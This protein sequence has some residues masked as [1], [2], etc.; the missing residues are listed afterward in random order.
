MQNLRRLL[1]PSLT[2]ALLLYAAYFLEDLLR[3]LRSGAA[4]QAHFFLR[5]AVGIGIWLAGAW[6]VNELIHVTIWNRAASSAL[7][8]RPVPQLLKH[9]VT[10]F[11]FALALTGILGFVFQK[12]VTGVWATSGVV[13]LVFGFAARSLIADL[14]CGI[15]LHLDPPFRIGDW[16]EWK[17]GN[18]EVLARVEQINWRSTRVHARDDTK[19]IFI[20][21]SMLSTVSVTNVFEPHGRTRQVVRVPLDADVDLARASRV[22]LAAAMS[23]EG[24][25][26]Q[27]PPDVLLDSVTTDGI[28]FCVR[29][30]HSPELSVTRVR[31]QVLYSVMGALQDAGIPTARM[32]HAVLT[33]SR[34]QPL[35]TTRSAFE[36]LQRV[37]LFQAF[38]SEEVQ[39]IAQHAVQR[40]L[41]QGDVVVRQGEP[42]RSLFFVAEG[43]LDVWIERAGQEVVML[44][45]LSAGQYFG[46]MSLLTGDPRSATVQAATGALLFEVD[47]ATL[48]PIL[49]RRPEVAQLLAETVAGRLTQNRDTLGRSAAPAN[50]GAPQSFAE[51]LL[52]R[53]RKFFSSSQ[54]V[55]SPGGY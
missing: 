2:C 23:A 28:I 37:P 10:L 39:A 24:P 22:L 21:N 35:P 8:G 12:S 4:T 13:G 53:I 26:Q 47:K 17:D 7:G 29:Y 41:S 31:H 49:A 32:R 48:E 9:L 40:E 19:T 20:P 18:E 36:I 16:I 44:N 55:H 30:W 34:P 50:G 46:E 3:E 1:W 52:G 43:L 15:A 51:L 14:F 42:G 5:H 54:E 33:E 25:L 45:R 6:L 38:S 27:P 11:L